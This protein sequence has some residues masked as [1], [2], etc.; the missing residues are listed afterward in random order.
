MPYKVQKNGSQYCVHKE[1]ADGSIGERVAC[2]DSESQASDQVRAL[3]AA[4]TDKSVSIEIEV[5]KDGEKESTGETM[6]GTIIAEMG[7]KQ[8]AEYIE[9]A[10]EDATEDTIG[11]TDVIDIFDGYLIYKA[12]DGWYMVSYS[13]DNNMVTFDMESVTP[14]ELRTQWMTKSATV[15][16][17]AV[18]SIG[19]YRVGGYGIIW[20][21]PDKRDSDDQFF[22]KNTKHLLDI[23]NA[24]GKIPYMVHHAADGK[25]KSTVLGEVDTMVMDDIGLW[26]EAKIIQ[27]DLYKNYVSRLVERGKMYSSSGALP[28]AVKALKT[29]EILDWP[30]AEMSCTWVPAEYRMMNDGY[31]VERLKAHFKDIGIDNTDLLEKADRDESTTADQHDTVEVADGDLDGA[32]RELARNW[33]DLQKLQV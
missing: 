18:K 2:H 15:N 16:P 26:Y 11:E 13:I 19:E 30:I 33:L 5:E 29:G 10:W 22:T 32:M 9:S 23:F 12:Q 8:K 1:N 14:V 28:A 3:Y 4:E 24:I 25:I 17:Y 31:S 20:G 27:Q 6:V 7:Y 21:S